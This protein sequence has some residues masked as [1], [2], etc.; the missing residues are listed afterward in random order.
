[1]PAS[2]VLVTPTHASPG[3]QKPIAYICENAFMSCA[4]DCLP[5]IVL[6]SQLYEKPTGGGVC[7]WTFL[8]VAASYHSKSID[9]SFIPIGDCT[10]LPTK[11]T[12]GSVKHPTF[13]PFLVPRAK[14]MSVS[15][16]LLQIAAHQQQILFYSVS[17]F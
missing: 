15:L 2:K 3:G 9:I 4:M 5:A 1:M 17:N 13:T 10:L 16:S 11:Y 12:Q 6:L 7:T 14:K 8:P